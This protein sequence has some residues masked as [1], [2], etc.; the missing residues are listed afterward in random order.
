M[1]WHVHCLYSPEP[2]QRVKLCSGCLTTVY[3][4]HLCQKID[5][6]AGHRETCKDI[7][8]ERKGGHVALLYLEEDFLIFLASRELQHREGAVE[9]LREKSSPTD[10]LVVDFDVATPKIQF[11]SPI[12]IE[13]MNL[14][15]NP[16]LEN[17]DF[18]ADEEPLVIISRRTG[19]SLVVC[20][21]VS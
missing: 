21:P 15:L 6:K 7:V 20:W 17:V 13:E 14:N 8:E 18:D 2:T 4:S 3:C 5:W 9:R 11:T 10:V 16:S 12:E 1:F 19:I